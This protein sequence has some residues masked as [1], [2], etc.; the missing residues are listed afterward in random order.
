MGARQHCS[1]DQ[2]SRIGYN[3]INKLLSALL[4]YYMA[5]ITSQYKPNKINVLEDIEYRF[6]KNTCSNQHQLFRT[7]I[8]LLREAPTS[9]SKFRVKRQKN[10]KSV[11]GQRFRPL[12][13]QD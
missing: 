11:V 2:V 8:D 7:K 5:D 9:L 4:V 6:L 12:E 13:R 1:A 3:L 10:V